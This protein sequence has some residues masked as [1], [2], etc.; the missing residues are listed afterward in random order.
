MAIYSFDDKAELF[1]N[2]SSVSY[3]PSEIIRICWFGA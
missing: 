1:S 3:D 2:L